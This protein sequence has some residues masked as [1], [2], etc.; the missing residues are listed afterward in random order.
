MDSARTLIRFLRQQGR[1]LS[2]LLILTHDHPD[3]D[4]IA[5]AWTL[6]YLAKRLSGVE[7]RIVY[8]GMIGRVEN[9]AMV[10]LL[11]IP[12]HPLRSRSDF[13]KFRA[14]AL[15]DTQPCFGN[16]PFPKEDRALCTCGSRLLPYA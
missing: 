13:R 4:A 11:D 14:V 16:N 6:S 3:P 7:S 9:Q 1:T 2:P 10:R 5:S 15:V 8:G 12:V